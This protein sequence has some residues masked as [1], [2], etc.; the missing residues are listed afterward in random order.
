MNLFYEISWYGLW[1]LAFISIAFV[2]ARYFG[3]RGAIT[4]GVVLAILIYVLDGIWISGDIKNHPEHGRDIDFVFLI[5]VL[6]RVILFNIVLLPVTFIAFRL[7][8]RT[9]PARDAASAKIASK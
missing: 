2:G 8:A 1:W 6:I 5:G 4:G 9:R 3:W 7:R